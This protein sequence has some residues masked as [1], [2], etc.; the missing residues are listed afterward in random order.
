[1]LS[2]P[3]GW[4]T[5]S[6][7]EPVVAESVLNKAYDEASWRTIGPGLSFF[8]VA[9]AGEKAK[10]ECVLL[11]LV[12]GAEFPSS[13]HAFGEHVLV[14]QGAFREAGARR[15]GEARARTTVKGTKHSL[16][17]LDG[18]NLHRRGGDAE[19]KAA[20]RSGPPLWPSRI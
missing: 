10:H 5:C 14:L 7:L 19:K 1:M 4:R 2:T 17:A 13:A 16:T 9:G 11:R 8:K 15:C 20:E 18:E 3:I 12:P 6:G